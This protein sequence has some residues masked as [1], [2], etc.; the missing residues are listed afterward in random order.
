MA[1]K[2]KKSEGK[3]MDLLE[4]RKLAW[5]NFCETGEIGAYLLYKKL[6]EDDDGANNCEGDCSPR[7]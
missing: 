5:K 2:S 1:K 6:S 3:D 4:I 7:D